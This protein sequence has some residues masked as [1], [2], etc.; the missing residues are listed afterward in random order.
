MIGPSE[1]VYR[2]KRR[3]PRTEPCGTPVES[4]GSKRRVKDMEQKSYDG[5][6][7]GW[8]QGDRR[9]GDERE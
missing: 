7:D 3:G 8:D 9:W 4:A 2:E 1:V 6:K 5:G